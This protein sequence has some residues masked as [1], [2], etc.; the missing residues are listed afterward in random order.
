V[1]ESLEE[2]PV[3]ILQE[4]VPVPDSAETDEQKE[5]GILSSIGKVS[6]AHAVC[7]Y[8]P[9]VPY[10]QRVAWAKLF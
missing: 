2:S 9:P 1:G 7:P 6:P 5:K 10:P 3:M 8:H 4:T